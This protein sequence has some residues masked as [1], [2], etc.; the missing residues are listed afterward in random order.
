MFG[1]QPGWQAAAVQAPA[2]RMQ[3]ACVVDSFHLMHHSTDKL[4][5]A[6]NAA[7]QCL[8]ACLPT[9]RIG[10]LPTAWT[11]ERLSG[12]GNTAG[13]LLRTP[14]LSSLLALDRCHL[15]AQHRQPSLSALR[16]AAKPSRF[17]GIRTCYRRHRECRKPSNSAGRKL[18][19]R[20]GHRPARAAVC[21]V[22]RGRRHV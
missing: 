13:Q 8:L 22:P 5:G 18:Q 12:G 3:C 4:N 2:W 19:V 11:A 10:R 1:T 17:P 14:K 16:T 6:S 9:C 7:L 15:P 21:L 20:R